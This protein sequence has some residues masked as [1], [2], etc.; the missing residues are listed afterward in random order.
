M[1]YSYWTL[2]QLRLGLRGLADLFNGP[3]NPGFPRDHDSIR[4]FAWNFL[5]C[6]AS[7]SNFKVFNFTDQTFFQFVVVLEE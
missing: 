7:E 6:Q 4:H 3:V 2:S 5:L 1:Y